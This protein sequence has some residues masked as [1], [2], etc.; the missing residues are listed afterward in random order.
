MEGPNPRDENQCF[1]RTSH[2]KVT[3]FDGDATAL[4]GKIVDVEIETVRA[5]TL[6]GSLTT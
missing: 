3:F 2:N 6:L 1:G 4:K 5:Y